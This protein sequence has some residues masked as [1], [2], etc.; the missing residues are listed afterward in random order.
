MGMVICPRELR[1]L[2]EIKFF[3][4]FRM[5]RKHLQQLSLLSVTEESRDS[6]VAQW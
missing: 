1:R 5:S 2:N 3:A 4:A 6:Q